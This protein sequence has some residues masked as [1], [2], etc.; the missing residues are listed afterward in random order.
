MYVGADIQLFSLSRWSV[1]SQGWEVSRRPAFKAHGVL[2]SLEHP[3]VALEISTLTGRV[4]NPATARKHPLESRQQ[5]IK[6]KLESFSLRSIPI[7]R[8][9]TRNCIQKHPWFMDIASIN[10]TTVLI[11]QLTNIVT[12]CCSTRALTRA[13]Q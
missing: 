3:T 1:Q 2:A 7:I 5:F 13:C 12:E 6:H 8:D 10:G 4:I 11:H 9:S